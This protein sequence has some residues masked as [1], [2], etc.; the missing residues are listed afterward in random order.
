MIKRNNS[1]SDVQQNI[2]KYMFEQIKIMLKDSLLLGDIKIQLGED[3]KVFIC[4]DFYSPENKIIGEIHVHIGRLKGAQPDKIA[5]DVLKM[6]LYEKKSGGEWK[7][8][9][10]VCCKEELEQLKGSSFLA[11]SIREYGVELLYVD[12]PAE[13]RSALSESIKRQ[14]LL[15]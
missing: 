3:A 2:E 5:S 14:N 6:L 8:Y 10:A 15:A 9:I 13:L 1:K 4:P 11:Q 12:L 7:K